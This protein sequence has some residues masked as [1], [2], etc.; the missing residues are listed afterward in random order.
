MSPQEINVTLRNLFNGNGVDLKG[1]KI[2]ADSPL[3]TKITHVNNT[4]IAF[5]CKTVYNQMLY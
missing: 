2:K 3:N 4:N 5:D 1:F